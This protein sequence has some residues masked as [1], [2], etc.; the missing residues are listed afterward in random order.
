MSQ[1]ETSKIQ[2]T[3]DGLR[4]YAKSMAVNGLIRNGLIDLEDRDDYIPVFFRSLI[5]PVAREASVSLVD[6]TGRGVASSNNIMP[7]VS[8]EMVEEG[9]FLIDSH[10]LMIVEPILIAGSSEGA[11]V[12]VYP[13]DTF[14]ELFGRPNFPYDLVID[15]DNGLVVYS[16]N[17]KLAVV[18]GLDSETTKEGW[19]QVRIPVDGSNISVVIGTSLDNALESMA[20][21]ELVQIISLMVL[22]VVII[23]LVILSVFIVSRP[24]KQFTADIGHL[25]F[26]HFLIS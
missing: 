4:D 9:A 8:P 23:G 22:L 5:A 1:R 11:I 3:L 20:T 15:G 2:H 16:T 6:Y 12:M 26:L 13:S 19:L 7:P 18:D 17:A 21:T 14:E 25:S 24:L 10:R